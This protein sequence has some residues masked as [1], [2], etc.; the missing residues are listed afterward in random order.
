MLKSVMT[1]NII[2]K[3]FKLYKKLGEGAFSNVYECYDLEKEQHCIAKI[4]KNRFS[5]LLK[6]EVEILKKLNHP[7]IFKILYHDPIYNYFITEYVK[8]DDLFTILNTSDLFPRDLTKFIFCEL[9]NTI[10]YIHSMGII[11]RDIKLEN[12]LIAKDQ[13]K[14]YLIDYGLSGYMGKGNKITCG[15]VPY[16]APETLSPEYH[17]DYINDIWS[18][19]IVLFT[20]LTKLFPVKYMDKISY[21][22]SNLCRFQENFDEFE[23]SKQDKKFIKCMLTNYRERYT[24]DQLLKDDWLKDTQGENIIKN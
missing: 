9:C 24:I 16:F 2:D 8:A 6:G 21:I 23:I 4:L 18:L 7:N 3:R 14:I 11:H 1:K 15:S 13:K 10:K 17:I 12:I 5:E 19:G 20:M 22:N